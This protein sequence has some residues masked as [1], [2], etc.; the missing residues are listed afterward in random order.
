MRMIN[1]A[2]DNISSI[3]HMIKSI[4]LVQYQIDLSLII[5]IHMKKRINTVLDLKSQTMMQCGK[6][7]RDKIIIGVG[8]QKD[9]LIKINYLQ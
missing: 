8:D 3:I 4:R 7:V 9:D 5:K 2:R 1:S 6:I